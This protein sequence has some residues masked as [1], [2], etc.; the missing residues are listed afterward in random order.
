[1]KDWF[2]F[3]SY[4]FYAYLASG[5]LLIAVAD[6]AFNN[7]EILA[8]PDWS[9]VASV[10][11]VAGAYVLGQLVASMASPML[12]FG[13]ARRFL[14]PPADILLRR[15]MPNRRER[16]LGVLIGRNYSPYSEAV[17][18]AILDKAGQ[19]LGRDRE[20]LDTESIFLVAHRAAQSIESTRARLRDFLNQY[21]FCRN[22]AM[23]AIFSCAVFFAS[24]I[25]YDQRKFWIYSTI[26]AVVTA[27]MLLRFL[28]FYSAYAS[29]VLGS[30]VSIADGPK[31][32]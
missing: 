2:P 3:S 26:A 12:E 8:R 1:M 21:G 23:V 14:S 9:L 22:I 31:K 17:V 11:F 13:L 25:T 5:S 4:D 7:G 30:L 6:L 28:K 16:A 32:S 27:G 20:V 29:E 24:A 10:V 15:K 19:S 18:S